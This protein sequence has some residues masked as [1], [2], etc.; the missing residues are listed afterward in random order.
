MPFELQCYERTFFYHGANLNRLSRNIFA[1]VPCELHTIKKNKEKREIFYIV[2]RF[3]TG[4]VNDLHYSV[5]TII[6]SFDSSKFNYPKDCMILRVAT[7]NLSQFGLSNQLGVTRK[8]LRKFE[9]SLYAR[10]NVKLKSS[11]TQFN[12]EERL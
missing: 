8:M 11:A 10:Q 2:G 1:Y 12:H 9:S 5:G 3:T 6:Q 7:P 4:S